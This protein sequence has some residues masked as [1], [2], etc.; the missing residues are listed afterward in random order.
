MSL[1]QRSQSCH[2]H[3]PLRALFEEAAAVMAADIEEQLIAKEC[4]REG[5]HQH[6]GQREPAVVRSVAAAA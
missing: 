2:L 3:R 4:A 1:D 6:V 5:G